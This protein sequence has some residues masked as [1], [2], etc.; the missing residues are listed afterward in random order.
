MTAH[1][2]DAKLLVEHRLRREGEGRRLS[3]KRRSSCTYGLRK[4]NRVYLSNPIR[5]R[6]QTR[7]DWLRCTHTVDMMAR[8]ETGTWTGVR[9]LRDGTKQG[10]SESSWNRRDS[11]AR[12]PKQARG[13]YLCGY[14]SPVHRFALEVQQSYIVSQHQLAV[15]ASGVYRL[16]ME[17]VHALRLR[18]SSYVE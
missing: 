11:V 3:R 6:M 14:S 9:A 16:L 17:I 8:V 1:A 10:T 5:P 12:P 4:K 18:C 7:E 13:H 15:D 2:D